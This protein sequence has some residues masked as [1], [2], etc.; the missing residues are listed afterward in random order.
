MKLGADVVG[1]AEDFYGSVD[2]AFNAGDRTDRAEIRWDLASPKAVAAAAGRAVSL[3][4]RT[5]LDRGAAVALDVDGS[6][7]PRRQDAA[8]GAGVVLVTLPPDPDA[9]A[10]DPAL[11][12]RWRLAVRAA[13]TGALAAGY[14]VAGFTAAGRYALERSGTGTDPPR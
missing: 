2:D 14:R 9:M 11:R 12:D 1:Y 8:T 13:M 5:L 7:G 4:D 10:A 3:D 6:G